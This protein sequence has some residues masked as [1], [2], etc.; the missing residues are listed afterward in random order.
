MIDWQPE[1][2]SQRRT[3]NEALPPTS[4]R[5][6]DEHV[7]EQKES[8]AAKE[9]ARERAMAETRRLLIELATAWGD[10][11]EDPSAS[12][13]IR[14]QGLV[15]ALPGNLAKEIGYAVDVP[16][17]H[18][19]M[20]QWPLDGMVQD[21]E[22]KKLVRE[23]APMIELIWN[24]WQVR[25]PGLVDADLSQPPR[26]WYRVEDAVHG[27]VALVR[28]R[29]SGNRTLLD[30]PRDRKQRED[31]QKMFERFGL[32]GQNPQTGGPT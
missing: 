14:V 3:F 4:S 12:S 29:E 27:F 11:Q 24:L 9:L 26:Y 6:C 18:W 28:E 30:G 7:K 17:D 5:A 8:N 31:A 32:P 25:L 23:N 22:D 16:R 15:G 1:G 21:S 19:G 2:E 10:Y 13:K 20:G